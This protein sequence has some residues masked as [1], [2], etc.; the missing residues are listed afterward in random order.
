MLQKYIFYLLLLFAPFTV[1]AQQTEKQQQKE[2][3]KNEGFAEFEKFI[4]PY[5]EKLE[6]ISQHKPKIADPS[7]F[8]I[9][10][11]NAY[12]KHFLLEKK[13]KNDIELAKFTFIKQNKNSSYTQV[14]VAEKLND[15]FEE[16]NYDLLEAF[17]NELNQHDKNSEKG[18]KLASF[19]KEYE[20]IR[21][22]SKVADFSL[23]D[24]NKKQKTL[25][26]YLGKYTIIDF[27]ASWC[28]P[29]RQENPNTVALYN[30][31]KN[32]GLK[33]IGVSLD[34]DEQKWI[35]AIEKDKLMWLHL[36]NLTGWKEPLLQYFKV[37]AI[38]KLIIVDKKGTIIAKDLKGEELAKKI[39]ELFTKK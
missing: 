16:V 21:I 19:L 27:W 8:T 17:Y 5:R 18:K 24:V 7:N 38:P 32:K 26:K 25:Y 36:S 4:K 20:Q 15:I 12:L 28:G 31:Y 37:T 29:C 6:E 35:T 14:L 34:T 23:P 9:E 10:E 30:K 11:R 22:G 39:D 1:S 13:A 3:S 2:N 33:I